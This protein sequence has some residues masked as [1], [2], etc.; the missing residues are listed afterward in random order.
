MNILL[1][2]KIIPDEIKDEVRAKSKNTMQDAAI[3]LQERIIEGFEKNDAKIQI[4][5]KMPIFSYP[6][7]YADAI[8]SEGRFGENGKNINLGFAI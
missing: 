8:V 2:S 7:W 1:L 5:N 3:S 6:K 4:I